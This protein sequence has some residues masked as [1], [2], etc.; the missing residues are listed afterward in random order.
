MHGFGEYVD[1]ETHRRRRSL[2]PYLVDRDG[3]LLV[4]LIGRFERLT[5]DA[6]RIFGSIGVKLGALPHEGRFTRRD[7]REF[8][9]AATRDKVTAHW[10]RDLDLLGYD[11]DGLVEDRF[12]LPAG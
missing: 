1:W 3:R 4:D 5:D 8:Y 12:P 10:A 2:T 6:A 9:D 7:Y 11:F